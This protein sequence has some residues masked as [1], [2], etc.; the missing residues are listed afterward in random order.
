ML[1]PYRSI[2]IQE[3]NDALV[4][5][6]ETEFDLEYP[7]AYQKLG[8]D[9]GDKSPYYLRQ[10][11]LDKLL[12][13]KQEL[14]LIKPNWQFKIFDAY[15]PIAIQQHMVDYTFNYICQEQSL[16]IQELTEKQT[17]D[18][19][20]QVYKIWAIPSHNPLT[21]PPHSTGSAIDLTLMTEDGLPIDMGGEID[22]LSARS[23]PNYYENSNK[24]EEQQYHEHRQILWQVMTKA[25]FLRH[26]QEWWHFS[27]GDQLWAWLTNENDS[28]AKT[29]AIY[30]NATGIVA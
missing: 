24:P 30:G 8:A 4:A 26:P 7:A 29:I 21:P 22:E 14:S 16:Q 6:P 23:N 27:Y 2:E 5:I 19:Y 18:I 9:Y 15:R 25:G 10:Q 17:E 13:A 11:V 1:K 20:Q 12:Q 28:T 3:C